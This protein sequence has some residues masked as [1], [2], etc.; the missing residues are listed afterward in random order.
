ML[1]VQVR[2]ALIPQG[3]QDS[4]NYRL[5][6]MASLLSAKNIGAAINAMFKGEV[7][8]VETQAQTFD[9]L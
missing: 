2:A 1:L 6:G 3:D 4:I 9:Y 7:P 5:G 8:A